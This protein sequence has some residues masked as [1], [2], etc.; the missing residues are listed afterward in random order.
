MS[1]LF[2][3]QD[4]QQ[5]QAL[6][7]GLLGGAEQIATVNTT[8]SQ[9]INNLNGLWRGQDTDGFTQDWASRHSH[10]LEQARVALVSAAETVERNRVAQQHTSD[11]LERGGIGAGGTG[12]S[13]GAGAAAATATTPRSPGGPGGSG[14]GATIAPSAGSR[15]G[16]DGDNRSDVASTGNP[17]TDSPSGTSTPTDPDDV[18]SEDY[19]RDFIG[20]EVPVSDPAR[21]NTLMESL[22]EDDLSNAERIAVLEEIGVIRGYENPADFVGQWE[23]YE[24]LLGDAEQRE[25][26]REPID[27]DRHPDFLGG[28]ASLRYGAVVGDVLGIDPVFGSLLNPSGGAVGP[29]NSSYEPGPNDAIGYHGIFHDAA[30]FLYNYQGEIVN[31]NDVPLGPGYDYLDQE[32]PLSTGWPGTGQISGTAWWADQPGL[33]TEVSAVGEWIG[34]EAWDVTTDTATGVWDATTDAA[35]AEWDAA[36]DAASDAWDAVTDAPGDVWDATTDAASAE[37]D[38]ATDAA[39]D[40]WDFTTDTA[41][42]VGGG[43]STLG[44]WLS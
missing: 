4:L 33:N 6:H 22:L 30:G 26:H 18:F 17:A 39:S 14:G 13:I 34:Q 20:Y 1:E 29:G 28:T 27:H 24:A 32:W 23:Q 43:L 38:A 16:Q 31:G 41:D 5:M 25:Y 12:G 19:M 35:S 37:W 11:T 36:T 3:G 2:I 21:L 9:L 42:A 44:E 40:A 15:D 10:A 8:S 7:S